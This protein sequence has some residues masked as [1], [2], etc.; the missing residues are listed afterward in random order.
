[1]KQVNPAGY[2]DRLQRVTAYIYD[3][4]DQAIDLNH[5]ADIACMSPY[6]WHRIYRSVYGE[7]IAA[8]VKRLRLSRAA[9]YLV[10]SN[11]TVQ[12]I[13][14]KT[15]YANVQSFTRLFKLAYGLPPAQYRSEGSHTVFEQRFNRQD[16]K[17]YNISIKNVDPIKVASIPHKGPYINIGNAFDKVFGALGNRSLDWS[18][19]RTIGIFYDDPDSHAEAD[20]R[21]RAGITVEPD[22]EI[23][24]P[25]EEA[26]VRDGRYAVLHYKG[27]YTDMKKAYMWLYGEWLV[28]SGEEAADAP[29]FELYLNN[30]RETPPT[31]LLTDIHLPLV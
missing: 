17:M 27:P 10:N 3:H 22:F 11:L 24:A 21:S 20:L 26:I 2:E 23:A 1:M 29:C 4:L 28:Q 16:A 30:P 6:H 9:A 5:L 13:A 19:A 15:G 25:L 12:E 31:E 8:T 18:M 14:G 7:T